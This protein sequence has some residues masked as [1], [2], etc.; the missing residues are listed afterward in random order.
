MLPL[1]A[2]LFPAN[3]AA[4]TPIYYPFQIVLG[5]NPGHDIEE[6]NEHWNSS[7]LDSYPEANLY[8]LYCEGWTDMELLARE[9]SADPAILYAEA[10]YC[11]ETPEGI[12]QMVVII[13]GDG[14]VDYVDQGMTERIGVD[15]AHLRSSGAGD[16][17]GHSGYGCGPGSRSAPRS[18]LA[19]RL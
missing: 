18:D 14:Y 17:R 9:M 15:D 12:R 2:G 3:R 6:V 8:L 11:Q 5:L 7:V 19:P 10:N 1:I 4:A 16:H 13:V